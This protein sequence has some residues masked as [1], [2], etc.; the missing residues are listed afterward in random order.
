[1]DFLGGAVALDEQTL[2]EAAEK[3]ENKSEVL[4]SLFNILQK[5]DVKPEELKPTIPIS[6]GA[7][8]AGTEGLFLNT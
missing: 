5:Y 6:A 4:E 1:M 8:P 7:T 2:A 3:T